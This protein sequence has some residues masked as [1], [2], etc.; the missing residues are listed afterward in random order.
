ILSSG[1]N[2]AHVRA[3]LPRKNIGGLQWFEFFFVLEPVPCGFQAIKFGNVLVLGYKVQEFF[4]LYSLGLVS[5]FPIKHI[6][7]R[8]RDKAALFPLGYAEQALANRESVMLS[9]VESTNK[10]GC[11]IPNL[12][13]HRSRYSNPL[14]LI[15]DIGESRVDVRLLGIVPVAKR[16]LPILRRGDEINHMESFESLF[17]SCIVPRRHKIIPSALGR[18]VTRRNGDVGVPVCATVVKISCEHSNHTVWCCAL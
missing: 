15:D 7:D 18:D 1:P 5:H 17:P 16:L 14:V 10:F 8:K 13:R 12:F 6:P 4:N 3:H 11:R 2:L 9:S